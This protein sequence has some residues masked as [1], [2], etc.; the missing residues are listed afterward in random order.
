MNE[1]RSWVYEPRQ[2]KMGSFKEIVVK[3]KCTVINTK[4]ADRMASS[5][6]AD[7]TEGAV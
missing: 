4:D 5:V 3:C 2:S 1:C 6:D 7:Q